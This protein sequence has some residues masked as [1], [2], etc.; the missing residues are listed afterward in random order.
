[1]S[2]KKRSHE[3]DPVKR[4]DVVLPTGVSAQVVRWNVKEGGEVLEGQELCAFTS[5]GTRDL[6]FLR[7]PFP[8][9]GVIRQLHPEKA[10][11]VPGYF[12]SLLAALALPFFC[13]SFCQLK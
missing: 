5:E 2:K 9:E 8:F 6:Q 10:V 11:V 13:F 7:S 1:M 4:F 3:E 12:P